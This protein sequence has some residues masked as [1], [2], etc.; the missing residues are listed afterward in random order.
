MLIGKNSTV[1]FFL[2]ESNWLNTEYLTTISDRYSLRIFQ[3]VVSELMYVASLSNDLFW[4]W[5][6]R[7]IWLTAICSKPV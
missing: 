5:Y 6:F 1:I 3:H 7:Q 4:F 2:L